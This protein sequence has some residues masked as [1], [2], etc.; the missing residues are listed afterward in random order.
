LHSKFLKPAPCTGL[1]HQ[2]QQQQ[3]VQGTP[4][5]VQNV[6]AYVPQV[7][8]QPENEPT[9][10]SF[11]VEHNKIPKYFREKGKDDHSYGHQKN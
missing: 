8:N 10:L 7:Q 2:T 11:K 5:N 3:Q 1:A 4:G 9:H 6:P